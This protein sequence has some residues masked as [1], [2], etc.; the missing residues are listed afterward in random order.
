MDTKAQEKALTKLQAMM[1]GGSNPRTPGSIDIFTRQS[2]MFLRQVGGP[3]PTAED[4]EKWLV[5]TRKKRKSKNYANV[6]YWALKR[7]YKANKWEFP[8]NMASS[9][10]PPEMYEQKQL[11]M[12]EQDIA[13]LIKWAAS[14]GSPEEAAMVAVATTYGLR[15]VEMQSICPEDFHDNKVYIAGQMGAGTLLI[16]TGKHGRVR[17][18]V[19][20]PEIKPYLEAYDW[21]QRLSLT[22]LSILFDIVCY[23]AGIKKENGLNWHGIRR[24]LAGT[25]EPHIGMANVSNYMRWSTGKMSMA[26]RYVL[27]SRQ[28]R[29][30]DLQAFAAIP[31]LKYWKKG[32]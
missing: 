21:S 18:H 14:N 10:R 25:L 13:T 26:M 19:I 23:K 20:P 1:S 5:S 29:E 27:A 24:T 15:R 7:L 8:E 17:G 12:K 3:T 31:W 22:H 2:R 30:I 28:D 6:A 32:E 11:P 9:P 4:A 16:R